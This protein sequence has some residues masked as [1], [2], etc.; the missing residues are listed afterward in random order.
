MSK[1]TIELKSAIQNLNIKKPY[2]LRAQLKPTL[3]APA[4][5]QEAQIEQPEVQGA[6]KKEP[7]QG[8]FMLAHSVFDEEVVRNLSGDAFRIF[9]WM[10][11]QAWRFKESKG[12]FRAAVDYISVKCGCSRSTVTRGLNDLKKNNLIEC[13]EQNFKKGNL[14]KVNR[15]ADGRK[16]D[17]EIELAQNKVEAGSKSGSSIPNLKQ[18]HAQNEHHIINPNKKLNKSLE[19]AGDVAEALEERKMIWKKF[20]EAFPSEDD[21]IGEIQKRLEGFPFVATQ[22]FAKEM[23][24]MK[25]WEDGSEQS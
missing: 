18:E 20:Y 8:F 14:W 16:E 19:A 6:Q 13:V 15:I 5:I 2:D 24:V 9:I 3:K 12:E 21:Q 10:S 17:A 11:A 7:A 25:W 1:N 23:A 4:Q 22:S